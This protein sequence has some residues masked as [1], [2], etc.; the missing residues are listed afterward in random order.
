MIDVRRM[1]YSSCF[2]RALRATAP[3]LRDGPPGKLGRIKLVKDQV[4]SNGER[5]HHTVRHTVF[6]NEPDPRMQG[7][8]EDFARVISSL[9][10]GDRTAVRSAQAK[11]HLRK[12]ALT[13]ALHAGNR[14][15]L[16]TLNLA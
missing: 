10:R 7:L 13:V 9:P 11:D 1:S 8:F 14:E 5:G 6:G 2:A 12:F 4:V 15:D 3:S 16:T